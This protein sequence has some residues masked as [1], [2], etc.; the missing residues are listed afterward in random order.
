MTSILLMG[1]GDLAK[2][3]CGRLLKHERPYQLSAIK[4]SVL[5]EK[6][7][8]LQMFYG[9]IKDGLFLGSALASIRPDIIFISMTPD[10]R[11]PGTGSSHYRQ[12]YVETL[13]NLL[14]QL[15]NV[16]LSPFIFWAS[17]TSVYGQDDGQW[18]DEQSV[19]LPNKPTA[20]I[21]LEAEDRLISC[22]FDASII[23]FSG[24]YDGISQRTLDKLYKFQNSVD[25]S[26]AELQWSNR[27]H[28]EDAA[29]FIEHLITKKMSGQPI[30]SLYIATDSC[31]VPRY[32]V[33]EY[34]ADKLYGYKIPDR[35]ITQLNG[36]RC[37]NQRMLDSGYVLQYCDYK[38]GYATT[39]ASLD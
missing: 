6:P 7:E 35:Q 14:V 5:P 33:T 26:A 17:S 19:T 10:S 3:L 37:S 13:N 16:K 12:A 9:D 30:D 25:I 28:R 20:K 34:L 1:Y 36:K 23:R 38:V 8:N 4:R 24:L 2:R 27:L 15:T 18:I 39:L 31:P 29:G 21:L 11:S 32:K 22:G